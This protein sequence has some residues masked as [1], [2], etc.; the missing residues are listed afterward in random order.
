M[1]T[2]LFV[3]NIA[4]QM[5]YCIKQSKN[6]KWTATLKKRIDNQGK[7]D[8]TKNRPHHTSPRAMLAYVISKHRHNAPYKSNYHQAYYENYYI[9]E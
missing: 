2:P 1:K 3:I 8:E 4:L 7:Q 6:T 5:L 9:R